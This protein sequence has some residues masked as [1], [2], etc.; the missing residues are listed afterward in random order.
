LNYNRELLTFNPNNHGHYYDGKRLLGVTTA[1]TAISKGDALIQWA[2]NQA[3]DYARANLLTIDQ[4]F[5]DGAKFIVDGTDGD[6][7]YILKGA[8]Y[9]W[10]AK[11]DEAASIGTI[12][13]NWIEGYLKGEDPSWPDNAPARKSCEAALDWIK[14]VKWET[15]KIEHQIYI[16]ELQVGGICDWYARINGVLAIPD[17]KTSKSL[18]S[19]Y[20]YQTAAYLKALENEFGEKIPHRWLVRIDKETGIVEPRFLPEEEIAADYAAFESAVTIY[21]RESELSKQWPNTRSG[22]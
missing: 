19:S 17:W 13:H 4:T 8:K 22:L 20:A 12:A 14:S 7:E 18:H 5:D 10:K 11:R 15:L 3:C 6:L 21:R 1:L 2:V 9:A 16:P